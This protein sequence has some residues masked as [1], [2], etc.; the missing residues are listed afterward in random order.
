MMQGLQAKAEG[1]SKGR[2][3]S[4]GA[5]D[6][7]A[8]DM[9]DFAGLRDFLNFAASKGFI[10]ALLRDG[11][12]E[13]T[14]LSRLTESN[15]RLNDAGKTLVENALRGAIVP[16]YDVLRDTPPCAEQAGSRDF[17]PGPHEGAEGRKGYV[18]RDHGGIAA[19]R[20]GGSC[21]AEG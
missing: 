6:A 4:Q 18:R 19:D 1:V 3:I 10:S 14:Q 11:V 7:L 9:A 20:Q 15:G 13:Q 17:L 16:N 5:L 21:G 2:L 8:A 12:L